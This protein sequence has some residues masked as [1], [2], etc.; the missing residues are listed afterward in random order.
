MN[1]LDLVFPKFCVGCRKL[2]VY[3]CDSCR[4]KIRSIVQYE[5]ICPVCERPAVDGRT[6]PNCRTRYTIDGLTAF[7]HYNGVIREAVKAI[8]YRF[9]YDIAEEF[10]KLV[11]TSSFDQLR[12]CINSQEAVII[13]IPLH[14]SRLRFRGFNQAE[15][16]GKILVKH[17][18]ANMKTDIL[19]R[20]RKTVPQVDMMD[21]Q[22]RLTNMEKAFGINDATIKQ[23]TN[24]AIVLFDD[25]FT[26]GATMRGAANVLKRVGVQSIWG[27]T[28]A[29]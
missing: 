10:I 24:R 21:R 6:H 18:D 29:R 26:T 4:R 14:P 15:V 25:V 12:T 3:F 1:I 5:T 7:F 20:M 27:V 13:P 22:E 28:M 9:A 8:K 2:G 19:M 17:L 23:Y 16:L 11:P